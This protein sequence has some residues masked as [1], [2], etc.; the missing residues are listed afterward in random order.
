MPLSDTRRRL[1]A[2]LHRRKTREREGLVLVEGV[3]AVTEALGAGARP[4][5]ALRSPRAEALWTPALEA[6]LAA[7]R[8]VPEEV[9]DAE[10]AEAA[11]TET[12]QGIL[13][14][15]DEPSSDP[16]SLLGADVPRLLLLDGVQDPG[17]AGTLV[18]VAAAFGCSGVVALDGTTDLW[19]AR[20]VRAAAG[21]AFRVPL[22]HR[23]WP[24]LAPELE[25]RGIPVLVAD[26]GGTPVHRAR[27]SGGWAL[28]VGGE[29]GGCRE[30]VREVAREVVAI[31][32]PG[33]VESLNVGVA[34]AI[35]LYELTREA[36]R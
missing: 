33:G 2:R 1:L 28:A 10:M 17:N 16:G 29:G 12:P 23:S 5:F 15:V 4:R 22:L 27:R 18:R 32:M 30:A 13:V 24:D 8:L 36:E 6:A 11:G 3:K 14:V 9:S 7:A 21:T 20:A 26:A 35:L 31:P 34:G 19:G 25:A